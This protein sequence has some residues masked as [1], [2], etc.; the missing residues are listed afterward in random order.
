MPTPQVFFTVFYLYLSNQTFMATSS[1]KI[2]QDSGFNDTSRELRK[3]LFQLYKPP[4]DRL[5]QYFAKKPKSAG[6]FEPRRSVETKVLMLSASKTDNPELNAAVTNNAL[7]KSD[8]FSKFDFFSPIKSGN[9]GE[10]GK[11]RFLEQMESTRKKYNLVVKNGLQKA[12]SGMKDDRKNEERNGFEN[13]ETGISGFKRNKKTAFKF[14]KK[15]MDGQKSYSRKTNN[16]KDEI[17]GNPGKDNMN[18]IKGAH[19]A[20]NNDE[21]NLDDEFYIDY[22]SLNTSKSYGGVT[23]VMFNKDTS[24]L[25]ISAK[26]E[27]KIVEKNR[28]KI[29]EDFKE[30]NFTGVNT[31]E[32]NTNKLDVNNEKRNKK[33]R[34]APSISMRDDVFLCSHGDEDK[35]TFKHGVSFDSDCKNGENI[36][37]KIKNSDG[38]NK[39]KKLI[40]IDGNINPW[41]NNSFEKM[42]AERSGF[43]GDGG[44]GFVGG[45]NLINE[46]SLFDLNSG[47]DLK[48]NKDSKEN[49]EKYLSSEINNKSSESKKSLVSCPLS[50]RHFFHLDF[51][52]PQEEATFDNF[53]QTKKSSIEKLN[54]TKDSGNKRVDIEYLKKGLKDKKHKCKLTTKLTISL[55]IKLPSKQKVES[56]KPHLLFR[57][58]I[59]KIIQGKVNSLDTMKVEGY[60]E[61]GGSLRLLLENKQWFSLDTG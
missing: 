1:N 7:N 11:R 35:G 36:T 52:T 49:I 24:N 29:D 34:L 32:S 40:S 23:D 26:F 15:Y 16:I 45:K 3:N 30:D 50:Q 21:F 61:E 17:H 41:P 20:N 2:D 27:E 5:K 4:K 14:D 44:K 39:T 12:D 31:H 47:K 38:E 13:I 60:L 6:V 46:Y 37:R 33:L 42:E 53:S 22:S 25:N 8:Y 48:T 28:K 56:D 58:E 51:G 9:Y 10:Q 43:D 18:F 57:H 19:K 59:L 54:Q 55:P